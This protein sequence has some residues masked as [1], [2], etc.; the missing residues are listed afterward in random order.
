VSNRETGEEYMR[1]E[2]DLPPVSIEV[3]S[4]IKHESEHPV[5]E[6]W[7]HLGDEQPH[8]LRDLL[9]LA[10]KLPA[11]VNPQEVLLQTGAYVYE[12]VRTQNIRNRFDKLTAD[13]ALPLETESGKLT[14][15]KPRRF[16]IARL[17]ATLVGLVFGPRH[18]PK[19]DTTPY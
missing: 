13:D 17:G 11:G 9:K 18:L 19:D 8:L 6:H 10:N 12:A 14:E 7:D 4:A 16:K 3:L 15:A 2:T 1:S 5:R